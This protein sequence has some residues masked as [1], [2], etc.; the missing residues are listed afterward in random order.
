MTEAGSLAVGIK[1]ST[2]NTITD[3]INGVTMKA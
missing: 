2:G 1:K 3:V